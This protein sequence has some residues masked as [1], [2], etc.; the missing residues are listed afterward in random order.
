MPHDGPTTPGGDN[1]SVAAPTEPAP[2]FD[3]SFNFRSDTPAGKDPDA[4]SPTLRAYHQ[5]LWSKTTPSGVTL[6]LD[7]PRARRQGYLTHT[8]P[9]GRR[10]WFGSDAIT[11]SYSRWMRPKAL[12]SAREAL[13]AAQR[14]RYLD[15]PYT[16]ASAMIWPVRSKQRSINQARGTR[17]VIA[18]RM[19]LT[20]ECIRRHYNGQQA[21]PLADVLAAH[22][23]FFAL[24]STFAGFV[25]FFHFQDWVNP[26]Y[27]SVNF[28][29]PLED[30]TRPGVPVSVQE[31]V[32]YRESVLTRIEQ[33]RH[34]MD[35]WVQANHS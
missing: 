18:D 1:A 5:L 8:W 10:E 29:L 24:F 34:R 9:D 7:A 13:D 21:S 12:V 4:H 2:R 30:F 15:P 19:D 35:A 20:L 33:R 23:D 32:S 3:G 26:S 11:G 28:F 16:I 14:A 6:A 25:E 31:Y 27:D 17:H 22:D